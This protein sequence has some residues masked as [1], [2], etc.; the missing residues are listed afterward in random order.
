VPDNGLAGRAWFQRSVLLAG[1]A[2]M[3]WA[4]TTH[5]GAA[6][7]H[8]QGL[9]I[10][11][12]LAVASLSWLAWVLL[13]PHGNTPLLQ[14]LT[15]CTAIAGS[16]LLLLYPGLTVYW[17]TFWACVSAGINFS[18]PVGAAITSGSA[19]ILIAGYADHRGTILGAFAATAFV[20]YVLGRNRKDYVGQAR[21]ATLTADTREREATIAERGRIARELHDVLGHS[22]TGVSLQIE[23]AAAA[24]ETTADAD[25]ALSHLEHAGKLVRTGQEEAVAAVR[26][27]REGEVAVH[28]M[29]E[30][31]VGMHRASGA[32]IRLT[33]TGSP[34][35]LAG[36]TA[37]AL[38]RVA[39]EALTNA[40]KHARGEAV[41]VGLCYTAKTLT[42]CVANDTGDRAHDTVSGGHGLVG[43]SERMSAVGGALNA[44]RIGTRWLVEAQVSA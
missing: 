11:I 3:V 22:L 1:L 2:A 25:Q 33:V 35:P 23:S 42:V 32:R 29:I 6:G 16:A 26:T 40:A 15:A 17:F 28:T 44:G 30:S 43:M 38:Y 37:L 4:M 13:G 19:A 14:V 34:R 12:V 7:L 21:E 10:S 24:L 31:L 41:E 39:Q 18:L 20:G 27:L 36:A 5:A 8:G 9:R